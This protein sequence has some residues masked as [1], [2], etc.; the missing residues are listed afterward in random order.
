MK[1]TLGHE[2]GNCKASAAS[3]VRDAARRFALAGALGLAVLIGAPGSARA[4][5]GPTSQPSASQPATTG[6]S[7]DQL[8]STLNALSGRISDASHPLNASISTVTLGNNCVK[9]LELWRLASGSRPAETDPMRAVYDR[10]IQ[11]YGDQSTAVSTLA[12]AGSDAITR[13]S[14]SV[15]TRDEVG[16]GA[17]SLESTLLQID[18]GLGEGDSSYTPFDAVGTKVTCLIRVVRGGEACSERTAPRATDRPTTREPIAIIEPRTYDLGSIFF[19]NGFNSR[20]VV[21]LDA[22]STPTL[23]SLFGGQDN[24]QGAMNAIAN[25]YAILANS[26]GDTTRQADAARAIHDALAR[27]PSGREIW[28]RPE[29]NAAMQALARG[30]LRGGLDHLGRETSFNAVYANLNNLHQIT[31]SQRAVARLHT[32]LILRFPETDNITEFTEYRRSFMDRGYAWDVLHW[33]LGFNYTNLLIS[34]REQQLRIDPALNSV[35][36]AGEPRMV[37][38][39]GHAVDL[40]ASVT[41][42]GS[43]FSQPVESTLLGRLG[44]LWWNIDVPMEIDGR[45]QTLSASATQPFGELRWN[46][47]FVGYEGRTAPFRFQRFGIGLFNLNPYLYFTLNQRWME[48]NTTRLDTSLTPMYSLNWGQRPEITDTKYY[49]QNRVGGDLR[50][51][52][53]TIQADRNWTIFFGPGIRYDYNFD[54]RIHTIE[55]Y[56]HGGVRFARGFAADIRAS[57]LFELGGDESY[58]VPNT[59]TGSLNLIL[60][61]ALWGS[62]STP[63]RPSSEQTTPAAPAPARVDGGV[64]ASGEADAGTD[65]APEQKP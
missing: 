21:A 51:I 62:S 57:Y 6:H 59:P 43:M 56:I 48:G 20:Q 41:W 50:P 27:I 15:H 5:E 9:I 52:D 2:P 54:P 35:T 53:V 33:D 26:P 31:V 22:T 3:S 63:S 32:G 44:V 29:F 38:G 65:A 14:A 16:A 13:L 8:L 47:E 45:T 46:N 39:T 19:L 11:L 55:P 28:T 24:A 17:Q 40:Q 37:E 4:Q 1:T 25:G 58:H 12:R 42:G 61:P 49:F 10:A 64:Q 23:N 60:T 7:A 36:S 34:G 18:R 30:D